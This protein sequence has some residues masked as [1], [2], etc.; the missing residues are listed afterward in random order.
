MAITLE[1]VEIEVKRRLQTRR[2]DSTIPARID[3]LEGLINK[4]KEMLCAKATMNARIRKN[5]TKLFDPVALDADGKFELITQL[6]DI[7]IE[8]IEY[9]SQ[10]L[11]AGDYQPCDYYPNYIDF[12]RGTPRPDIPRFTVLNGNLYI[13]TANDEDLTGIEVTINS[14]FTPTITDDANDCT[15]HPAL[16]EEFFDIVANEQLARAGVSQK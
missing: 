15:L 1:I 7:Y 6:P 2:S 3:D 8:G 9:G 14:I 10:I 16:E 5:L 11:L 4:A 13:R 12:K